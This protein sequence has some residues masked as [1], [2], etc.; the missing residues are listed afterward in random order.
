MQIANP[1]EK[2]LKKFNFM[3]KWA[4]RE[5]CEKAL[6]RLQSEMFIAREKRLHLF[7]NVLRGKSESNSWKS[8]SLIFSY[9]LKLCCVFSFAKL[10]LFSSVLLSLEFNFISCRLKNC[11]V[12]QIKH[13]LLWV[14]GG[15][16]FLTH[17]AR[18]K[19]SHEERKDFEQFILPL[20]IVNAS[21]IKQRKMMEKIKRT[22][23]LKCLYLLR[24]YL[25]FDVLL[26]VVRVA[27]SMDSLWVTFALRTII[28]SVLSKFDGQMSFQKISLCSKLIGHAREACL[29]KELVSQDAS[30]ISK[31]FQGK[32]EFLTREFLKKT[33]KSFSSKI[34]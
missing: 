30:S 9:F 10:K 15:S 26:L 28:C 2:R 34:N 25:S 4:S 7:F 24:Q 20:E 22:M 16:H 8:F 13:I 33:R 18:G 27:R 3:F 19:N 5:T 6:E 1:S 21:W 12:Y 32:L 23:K 31:R 17:R 29:K 11:L 14:G